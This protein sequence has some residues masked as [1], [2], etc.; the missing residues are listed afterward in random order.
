M[1]VRVENARR[2]TDGQADD[3]HRHGVRPAGQW[4]QAGSREEPTS[5]RN[6][7][8]LL[9]TLHS[10]TLE[11]MNVITARRRS[12]QE[13]I[14]KDSCRFVCAKYPFMQPTCCHGNTLLFGRATAFAFASLLFQ[15]MNSRGG[16]NRNTAAA[17]TEQ[18]K[19]F[20]HPWRQH[21]DSVQVRRPAGGSWFQWF[22][23]Q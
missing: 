16:E 5:G 15:P 21:T 7:E 6:V 4:V 3:F 9:V 8:H 22:I 2:Y 18:T 14:V 11:L 13:Q 1:C 10:T 20:D 12:L 17:L 23:L 19:C